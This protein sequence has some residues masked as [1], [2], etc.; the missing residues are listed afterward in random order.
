MNKIE[1]IGLYRYLQETGT[2]G[3][4][5]NVQLIRPKKG[6]QIYDSSQRFT[7]IYEIVSG[8]VKLGNISVKGE[9]YIYELVMAGEFFGNLAFLGETFSEF[10]KTLC[11]SELRVYK[12]AFFKYLMTHDPIMAEWCFS[13]IVFRWNKTET[14]LASIRSHE[15]RERILLTHQALHKMI[16]T[17]NGKDALLSKLLTNK[18]I[19]DLTATTRQLVADTVK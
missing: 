3:L 17:A 16:R 15:P 11:E 6:A 7:D 1:E 2:P 13:K 8:A 9:E 19:A 10:C 12:P 5:E 14:L 4:K 18:D